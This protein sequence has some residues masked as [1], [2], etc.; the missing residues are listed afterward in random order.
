MIL[1]RIGIALGSVLSGSFAGLMA[2]SLVSGCLG[3]G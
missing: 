2:G 1:A 3:G